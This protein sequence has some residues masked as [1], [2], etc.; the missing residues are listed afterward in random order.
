VLAEPHHAERGALVELNHPVAGTLRQPGPA[1][2]LSATPWAVTRAP[3]LGEHN[4]EV[5]GQWL[6][7]TAL[8]RLR[9]MGAI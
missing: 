1:V 2:R 4:A 3:L 8:A 9:A 7:A 5:W 6:G